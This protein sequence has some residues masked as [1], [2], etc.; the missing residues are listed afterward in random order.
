MAGSFSEGCP[1][2]LGRPALPVVRRRAR[3]HQRCGANLDP[4]GVPRIPPQDEPSS[5]ARGRSWTGV[6]S[7]VDG[8]SRLRPA[9]A[10]LAADAALAAAV[11][12]VGQLEVWAPQVMHPGNL[13]GPVWIV[14]VGYF[15]VGA[16]VA[17]RRIWP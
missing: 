5:T 8:M 9:H 3:P 10:R 15:A 1:S 14:S 2:T 17:V 6:R 7:S 13:A 12:V 4:G 11:I 16:L